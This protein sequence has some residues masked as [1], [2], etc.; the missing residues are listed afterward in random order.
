MTGFCI[1]LMIGLFIG[2][3]V[4]GYFLFRWLGGSHSDFFSDKTHRIVSSE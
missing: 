4:G 1:G 2:C 3:W